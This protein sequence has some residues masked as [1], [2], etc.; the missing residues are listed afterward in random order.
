MIRNSF[1]R[2]ND[3]TGVFRNSRKSQGKW[4]YHIRDVT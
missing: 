3:V 2:A 4:D 1:W